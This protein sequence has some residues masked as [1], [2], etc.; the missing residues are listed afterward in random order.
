MRVRSAPGPDCARTGPSPGFGEDRGRVGPDG[1]KSGVTERDL[2]G[3]AGQQIQ[4]ERHQHV[5]E[6][7]RH[8]VEDVVVRDARKRQ[9]SSGDRDE[10]RTLEPPEP[11]RP[12]PDQTFRT[13]AA[14]NNPLGLTTRTRMSRMYVE[15][16]LIPAL[17]K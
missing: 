13:G 7:A 6:Q 9:Q 12:H 2:S 5:D 1:E 8:D 11:V 10:K 17:K 16:C 15:T 3:I 4:A 14:P